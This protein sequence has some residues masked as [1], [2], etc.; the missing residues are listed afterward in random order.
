MRK[1]NLAFAGSGQLYPAFVGALMCL[2]DRGYS[3][4]EISGTSGG[5]IIAAAVASGIDPG[6]ELISII[7]ATLPTRNK[8]FDFSLRSL[9]FRWGL[10][11]GKKIEERFSKYFCKTLSE[12]RIPVYITASNITAR[13]VRVFSSATDP[14]FLT[15]KAVRAS[16]SLPF[17]FEPVII[18]E[19]IYVDGG[20]MM[21]LPCDVFS[22]NL[23]VLAF[24]FKNRNAVRSSIQSIAKY[25]HALLESVIDGDAED[26]PKEP[27]YVI[28]IKTKYSTL[29]FNVNSH[30][31]DEM[32]R[33]GYISTSEWLDL[34]EEKIK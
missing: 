26:L 6:G 1:I 34:N 15:S 28:D 21:N 11:K 16:I 32:M 5:A 2:K 7:K 18:D 4:S 33:E 9:L 20:W 22:N 8:L 12:C 13:R 25:L 14:G 29:S 19:D 27:I 10:I 17:I 24:R 30:D 3:I 31:V 23:P